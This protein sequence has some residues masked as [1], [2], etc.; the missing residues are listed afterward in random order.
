MKVA[1][2]IIALMLFRFVGIIPAHPY[3]PKFSH[4]IELELANEDIRSSRA[5]LLYSIIGE[6]YMS[7]TYSDIPVSWGVD[8]LEL[9]KYQITEAYHKIIDAAGKHQIVI[10]SEN[11]LK[12]QHRIF[13]SK[14]ITGLAQKGYRHLGLETLTSMSNSNTLLDSTLIQRGYPLD[15]PLTGTYTLEPKMGELVRASIENN[16]NLFAYEKTEAVEGKDRDEIQADNII[17]YLKKNP[18]SKT[19]IVCGF[20]HAIESDLIK[21]GSSFWMAKYLKDKLGVDPLTVYQDN[22]TEKFIENE[23]PIFK[24]I[25]VTEPSVFVDKN[26]ELVK[27]SNNVDIEVIHPKTR[28]IDGRPNWCYASGNHKS[29]KVELENLEIDYPIIVSAYLQHET[30]AVPI[31]RIEL[32]HKYDQKKLVLRSGEYKISIYDGENVEEYNQT[33]K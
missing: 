4:Q 22:F 24:S 5:G 16:Y 8:T 17:K 15:S 6:Y 10:I 31:D 2:T 33:V 28:Y 9:Q 19:V 11:H 7:N 21:R 13:A 18:N 12:P 1:L 29:V 23:H 25:N 27:I 32:K 20:H 3:E 30:N 26:G 14:L